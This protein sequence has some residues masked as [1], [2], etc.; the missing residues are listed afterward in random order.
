MELSDVSS[1]IIELSQRWQRARIA[2]VNKSS[3]I[4]SENEFFHTLSSLTEDVFESA[5]K[6]VFLNSRNLGLSYKKAHQIYWEMGDFVQHLRKMGAPCLRGSWNSNEQSVSL[7]REGCSDGKQFGARYCQYWREALDGLV[8][9]I[10]EDLGFVRYSSVNSGESRCEDVIF[11]DEFSQT[12]GIWKSQYRWGGIPEDIRTVLNPIED[13]FRK[14]K[15]EL[16]FLGL[17]EKNLFYKMESSENLTCGGA[18]SLYRSR[19]TRLVGEHFP[20]FKLRDASP[21]AVYGERS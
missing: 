13:S 10:G 16:T 12:D 14:M 4:L 1:T 3:G 7:V 6:Q 21:L 20:D 5:L 9:G 18:G 11:D 19:L 2:A 15:L 8:L 17:S